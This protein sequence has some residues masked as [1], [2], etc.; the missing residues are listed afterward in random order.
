MIA[1]PHPFERAVVIISLVLIALSILLPL[2]KLLPLEDKSAIPLH[3]SV[4]F[5]VDLLGPWYQVFYLPALGALLLGAN[6]AFGKM[7]STNEK[8]LSRFFQV[9]TLICEVVL[10]VAVILIVLLNL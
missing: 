2:W 8:I 10:F 4:I 7:L 9:A 3:Y 5:G 6:H 1:R